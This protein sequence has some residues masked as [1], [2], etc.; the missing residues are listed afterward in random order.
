MEKLDN[1]QNVKKLEYWLHKVKGKIQYQPT[2][3]NEQQISELAEEIADTLVFETAN[4]IE[5]R[6][7]EIL[8]RLNLIQA[9]QSIV[10]KESKEELLIEL[11]ELISKDLRSIRKYNKI[12][13][14]GVYITL[15]VSLILGLIAIL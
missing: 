2:L 5:D 15:G 9:N 11:S 6:T 3:R 4:P 12:I 7:K 13:S 1:R 10:A 8:N 14:I